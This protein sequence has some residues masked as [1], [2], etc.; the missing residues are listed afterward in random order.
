MH[1]VILWG[2]AGMHTML[3]RTCVYGNTKVVGVLAARS[4]AGSLPA[5]SAQ[6]CQAAAAAPGGS[7]GRQRWGQSGG[8][9]RSGARGQRLEHTSHCLSRFLPPTPEAL[10]QPFSCGRLPSANYSSLRSSSLYPRVA[11]VRTC[12]QLLTWGPGAI[13]A[14]SY[15]HTGCPPCG[16]PGP[17]P[18]ASPEPQRRAAR[19]QRRARGLPQIE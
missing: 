13:A 19:R 2:Q 5:G 9:G 10:T 4:P 1:A 14:P 11:G 6:L 8:K 3:N 18:Q 17:W 16:G 12:L 15:E 7:G